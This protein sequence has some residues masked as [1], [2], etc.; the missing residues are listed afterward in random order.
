MI[1]NKVIEYI[2]DTHHYKITNWDNG[3]SNP[4]ALQMYADEI[5]AK[6]TA[7]DNCFGFIG[8]TVRAISKPGEWQRVMYNGHKRMHGIKFQPVALPNGL[9]GNMYGPVSTK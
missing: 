1:T 7:L 4:T 3:I 8:G 2:H 6:G 5:S 9:V